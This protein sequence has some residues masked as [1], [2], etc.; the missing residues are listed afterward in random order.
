MKYHVIGR[1]PT[2]PDIK[3]DL[4]DL[5]EVTATVATGKRGAI[6][7]LLLAETDVALDPGETAALAFLM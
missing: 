1:L 4:I 3:L 5:D 6:S 7:N 2:W